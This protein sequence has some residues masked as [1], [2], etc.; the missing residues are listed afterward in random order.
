MFAK[1][2]E[3]RTNLWE[4]GR[5]A[6]YRTPLSNVPRLEPLQQLLFGELGTLY[7]V[8]TVVGQAK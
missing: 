8:F 3:T 5:Y 1:S 7:R 2:V 6:A 4:L